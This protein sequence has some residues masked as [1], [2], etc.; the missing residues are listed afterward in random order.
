MAI[1]FLG[2]GLSEYFSRRGLAVLAGPLHRTG[3]FLPFLPL[4][5]FW[6]QAPAPLHV[7]AQENAPALEPF[8]KWVK[9]PAGGFASHAALWFLLSILYTAVAATRRS[10]RFALLA[11]LAGNFGLWCL[12]YYH[13]W[14][15]VV[16]PQLWL[17]PLALIALA[18]EHINRDR[19]TLA[20]STGL[21][22]LALGMLY[23]SSTADMFIAGVGNSAILPLVLAVLAVSGVLAGIVLRVRGFLFLGAGFL[24]L[25]I[26]AMIWHAAVDL[27]Q[28]WVWWVSGIVL[29]IAIVALFAFFEKRRGDVVRLIED[30]K[31]WDA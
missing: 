4:L 24:F 27:T 17:I 3:V 11:A 18:A 31:S 10:F 16:H 22:Y 19:L 15:F 1:A 6:L 14:E 30:I 9:R 7:F 28:T 5:V 12:L 26:F 21:R 20:Q 29:G 25:D 8:L 2:V 23:L 13:G